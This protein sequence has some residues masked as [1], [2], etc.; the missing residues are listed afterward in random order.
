MAWLGTKTDI[1]R[2]LK[3][4]RRCQLGKRHLKSEFTLFQ[5]LSRLFLL[6]QFVKCWKI[7]L[8]LILIVCT[9]C[10]YC[11][12]QKKKIVVLCSCPPQN[13]KLGIS[14]RRRATTVEKCTKQCNARAKLL[15]S[16]VNQP[17]VFLT[18]NYI[19]VAVAVIVSSLLK[20]TY[21]F[22]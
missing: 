12:S 19:F 6:V 20:P 13:V 2:E 16:N 5:T 9:L 22:C 15:F 10:L 1:D 8:E 4:Q 18:F 11:S 7:F 17:F 14:R 3:Q 21:P